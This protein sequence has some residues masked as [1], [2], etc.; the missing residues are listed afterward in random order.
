MATLS[1]Q[2]D[3]SGSRSTGA[4]QWLLPDAVAAELEGAVR[5]LLRGGGVGRD[6]D[7]SAAQVEE[8][9][10]ARVA[11]AVAA[12][13]G[14][15]AVR[16]HLPHRVCVKL[17][18]RKA[19][20]AQVRW[21]SPLA[22]LQRAEGLVVTHTPGVDDTVAFRAPPPDVQAL[23]ARAVRAGVTHGSPLGAGVTLVPGVAATAL[24]AVAA[25]DLAQY[26]GLAAALV[27]QRDRAS[28]GGEAWS[29]HEKLRKLASLQ[30]LAM[31]VSHKLEHG[32]RLSDEEASVL[33]AL[34]DGRAELDA[35]AERERVGGAI[36]TDARLAEVA[37]QLGLAPPTPPSPPAPGG[38]AHAPHSH[39]HGH[40]HHG[41]GHS[42]DAHA[43]GEGDL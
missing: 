14:R 24:H 19:G 36:G 29:I 5:A 33:T 7:E 27:A 15:H 35:E 40:E 42:H 21:E 11:A 18:L 1:W 17:V 3:Y 28:A 30:T 2:L 25:R 26:E 4:A 12:A 23:I 34:A 32:A 20:S 41:H 38:G 39:S 6:D 16:L 8:L 31:S 43:H 13:R 22:A 10:P 37:A 9:P